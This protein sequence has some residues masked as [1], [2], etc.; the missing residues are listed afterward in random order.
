M[1]IELNYKAGKS[2]YLQ[3][4]DQVKHAAASGVLRSG[5]QLPSIRELAEQ[6]RVNRNTV[7]KAYSELETEGVVEMRQGLGV[8]VKDGASGGLTKR[9]RE[10]ILGDSIDAA[11]VQAHHLRVAREPFVDLV[12]RRLDQFEKRRRENES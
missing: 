4:V 3:I 2:P 6:L 5:D 7:A 1:L 12:H 11:I 9:A 10:D 8:F